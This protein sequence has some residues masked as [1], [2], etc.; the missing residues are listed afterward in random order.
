[1][2][3]ITWRIVALMVIAWGA[4][5]TAAAQDNGR[6]VGRVV[7]EDQ[8]NAVTGATVELVGMSRTTTSGL[9]GRFTLTD[10]PAGTVTLRVRMLGYTPKTIT[11]I[12]LAAG[13]VVEQV[14][15]VARQA[16]QLAEISVSVEAERGSVHQ[17]LDEQRSAT[18]VLSAVTSEQIR[19]SPDGDAA[20]AAQRVSGVTVQEGKFVFVRGLGERYTT[21][22]LNGSRIPSPEPERKSVP[23]D[24]FPSGLLQSITTAKTFTPNLQGDFS[25]GQVD[26]RTREYPT[27]RQIGL[28]VSTGFT[29]G[30]TGS[31]LPMAPTEGGEW[32]AS[33]TAPRRIPTVVRE[34][35][36]P[37]P[38]PQTN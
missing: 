16:L 37:V 36:N 12:T 31:T 20:A 28:S 24:L 21:T 9:D 11:G 4:A 35:V 1:M 2:R 27:T 3:Q 17:A 23:L 26:I 10:I 8:G 32:Y 13:G 30:V 22:T 7:D 29:G 33:A 14:V 6:I 38:G 18:N 5:D 19:R 15:G 34:T 25:G